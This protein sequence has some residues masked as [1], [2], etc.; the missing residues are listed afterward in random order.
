MEANFIQVSAELVKV[1][2]ILQLPI[3]FYC[4]QGFIWIEQCFSL[5]VKPVELLY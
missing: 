3:R 2:F 1:L 5:R 4:V